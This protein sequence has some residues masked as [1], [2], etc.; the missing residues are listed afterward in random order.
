MSSRVVQGTL[1]RHAGRFT[2]A[3]FTT[4]QPFDLQ[5]VGVIR[6]R[7]IT[8]S[9]GQFGDLEFRLHE[10]PTQPTVQRFGIYPTQERIGRTDFENL[11]GERILR[12]VTLSTSWVKLADLEPRFLAI[13]TARLL[14]LQNQT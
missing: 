6:R 13:A 5:G 10:D 7:C 12:G 8:N 1:H 14:K 4:E 2:F 3:F 9:G 11:L